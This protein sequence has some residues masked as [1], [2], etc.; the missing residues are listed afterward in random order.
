MAAESLVDIALGLGLIVEETLLAAL[1]SIPFGSLLQNT[2]SLAFR[3]S[4][5]I[6]ALQESKERAINV[7]KR[8]IMISAML[9]KHCQDLRDCDFILN[10][11]VLV[12]ESKLLLL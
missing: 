3:V 10:D 8:C 11:L 12:L 2:I 7:K 4:K 9:I 1:S 5:Y 6:D